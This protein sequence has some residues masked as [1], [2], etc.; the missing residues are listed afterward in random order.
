M[1]GAIEQEE[2]TVLL[3]S[4]R[5]FYGYDFTDYA[6]ASLKRRITLF[7]NNKRISTVVELERLLLNNEILFEEF[8]QELSVTVTE[9]FRDPFFYKTLR[10]VVMPRLATYPFIK[11]WVAGC[12]TGQEVYSLSIL[13]KEEGLFDR[14]VIYATDINQKSLH[15]AREGVYGVENMKLYTNNYQQA[16][17]KRAFSEYYQSKYDAVM[18]DRSLR[19]NVV[20]S[21]HNLAIDQ[22][23][24]EFQLVLCRNV[25]MY[26][27][28]NL[29]NKVIDLL[30][31]SLC[32]FGF[33]GFGDKESLLFYEKKDFFEETDRKAKIFRKVK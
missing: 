18:F 27:N 31:G 2:Y 17:G 9:M 33:I 7:M 10:E 29:Q 1:E 3:N 12:A 8:L 14:S 13:L 15:I 25:I 4:I 26:F 30:Y 32:T 23:F 6:E 21:A 24:N 16:G 5:S 19:E 22:S 20:F 28:Q 11:I